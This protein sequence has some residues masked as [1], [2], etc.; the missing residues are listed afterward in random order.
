MKNS[1]HQTQPLSFAHCLQ[2]SEMDGFVYSEK[3][4]PSHLVIPRHIHNA[5][6]QAGNHTRISSKRFFIAIHDRR[7]AAALYL[8]PISGTSTPGAVNA[9]IV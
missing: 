1:D 7:S 6:I 9:C 4:Y 5:S 2:R 3:V 8:R